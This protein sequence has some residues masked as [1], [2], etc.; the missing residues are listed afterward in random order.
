L[1]SKSESKIDKQEIWELVDVLDYVL[2]ENFKELFRRQNK[3]ALR[4]E[5]FLLIKCFISCFD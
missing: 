1:L 3:N 4:S 5:L 2:A